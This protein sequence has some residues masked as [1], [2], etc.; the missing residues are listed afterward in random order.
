MSA[1][2]EICN[3]FFQVHGPV[4]P[5]GCGGPCLLRWQVHGQRSNLRA[6]RH[7]NTHDMGKIDGLVMHLVSDETHAD[8]HSQECKRQEDRHRATRERARVPACTQQYP[9]QLPSS[10][11]VCVHDHTHTRTDTHTQCH[12]HI[13]A[14][15]AH[16]FAVPAVAPDAV[17]LADAGAP[18]VLAPA[19]LAVMLADT[20]TPAVLADAPEAVMLE[21]QRGGWRR[22]ATSV[23]VPA[24]TRH[25]PC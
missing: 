23:R 22:S 25:K 1:M 15:G 11:P 2:P 5:R 14:M 8:V 4:E 3:V 20:R 19:P 9:D 24:C 13:S 18:A 10:L 7:S 21:V 17:M 6:R 16:A 12:I